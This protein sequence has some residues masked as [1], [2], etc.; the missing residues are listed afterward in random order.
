MV[1]LV[2]LTLMNL[3]FLKVLA[4]GEARMVVVVAVV[5]VV[6]VL[7]GV[8]VVPF[9]STQ[10]TCTL[11]APAEAVDKVKLS[12]GV[13]LITSSPLQCNHPR[14]APPSRQA[15][16]LRHPRPRR[17]RLHHFYRQRHQSLL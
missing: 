7:P 1:A 14:L 9:W 11:I 15:M 8:K 16:K 13:R 2:F 12:V 10:L 17:R 4:A 3:A 5:I 6:L